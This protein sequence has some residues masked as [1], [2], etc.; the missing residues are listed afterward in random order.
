VGTAAAGEPPVIVEAPTVSE[1]ISAAVRVIEK[2]VRESAEGDRGR[3]VIAL[4]NA[5]GYAAR[6]EKALEAN[7]LAWRWMDPEVLSE[8]GEMLFLERLRACAG[9]EVSGAAVA[10]L[11]RAP[12]FPVLLEGEVSTVEAWDLASRLNYVLTLT[13]QVTGWSAILR[14]VRGTIK[15]LHGQRRRSRHWSDEEHALDERLLGLLDDTAKAVKNFAGEE[16][17]EAWA[18]RTADILAKYA[19]AQ[20][21]ERGGAEMRSRRSAAL[22][23]ALGAVGRAATAV[24]QKDISFG[25]FTALY[26]T[27]IYGLT[28]QPEVPASAREVLLCGPET[29]GALAGERCLV[30]GFNDGNFPRFAKPDASFLR[31]DVHKDQGPTRARQWMLLEKLFSRYGQVQLWMPEREGTEELLPSQFAEALVRDGAA[32][33][34]TA[35]KYLRDLNC[36][37]QSAQDAAEVQF[38]GYLRGLELNEQELEKF[39]RA[40]AGVYNAARGINVLASRSNHQLSIYDGILT[41]P[42]LQAWLAAWVD[43]HVFS[44]SQLDGIVGCSFRFFVERMLNL[45]ELEE[46]DDLLPAHVFGSFAH[47]VLARF[48]RTWVAEGRGTLRSGDEVLARE[49]LL[50][51]YHAEYDPGDDLSEFARDL[52]KLKLFGVLGPERFGE[53]DPPL[54]EVSDVGVFGKFLL[55]EMQRGD[56][57]ALDFLHPSNFEVGFGIPL[58]EEEDPLSTPDCVM[59]DV[60]QGNKVRLGGRIDRIDVSETGIFAVTD[61]KTGH[62]PTGTEIAGGFRTQLPVYMLVAQELLKTKYERPQ[63][64]GGLYYSLK[65]GKAAKIS[66]VFVRAAYQQQLGITG[67]CMKDEQFEA[68]L[69]MVKDRIRHSMSALRRGY[70]TTTRHNPDTVCSYCSFNKLCYRDVDRTAALWESLEAETEAETGTADNIQTEVAGK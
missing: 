21:D 49:E 10:E 45:D 35:E 44:V 36:R 38:A 70:L 53:K 61:Y 15:T 46:A 2:L 37:E 58:M 30:L 7:G 69:G 59:M 68:T 25:Y 18:G 43:R 63:A 64:A 32:S 19:A 54:E 23:D 60:G 5:R 9:R 20:A 55:M 42:R 11:F 14:Q 40:G 17:V 6:V 41:D 1:E 39:R 22:L 8:T 13:G 56:E 66:G 33:K 3:T 16:S 12:G 52:M 27:A 57:H 28:V 34:T 67:R 62:L 31:Q 29:A 50:R 47:D 51:A 24:A 65:R 48:Y 26:R 4:P